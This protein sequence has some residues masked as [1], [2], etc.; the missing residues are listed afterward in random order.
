MNDPAS[1][2]GAFTDLVLEV[3]RLNGALIAAGDALTRDLGLTSA[4]WQVLGAVAL[5]GRPLTVAGVARGMG[6]TRQAVR[7]VVA[8][9]GAAG[10]VASAPNP[11]HRRADLVVLTPAGREA[12]AAASARQA[13]WAGRIGREC[14]PCD[15]AGTAALL[16][17]LR[18]ALERD[19]DAGVPEEP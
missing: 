12:Y 16:R 1:P 18:A 7:R 2:V 13:A 10:L 6:L 17:R 8:D 4:R 14:G 15:F 11:D 19:E 3:F 9:L 5:A